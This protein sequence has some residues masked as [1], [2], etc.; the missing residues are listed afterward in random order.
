MLQHTAQ[1]VTTKAGMI[2]FCKSLAKEVATR[3]VTVNC[4]S[5]DPWERG[6][7]APTRR[8]SEGDNHESDEHD[9]AANDAVKE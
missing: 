5:P 4:V 3:G 7:A 2:G 9:S 1:H 8:K 6:C